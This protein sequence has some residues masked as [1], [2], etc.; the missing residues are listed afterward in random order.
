MIWQIHAGVSALKSLAPAPIRQYLKQRK[1]NRS[2]PSYDRGVVRQGTRLIEMIQAE[3][4]SLEGLTVLEIG[5]G[6]HPI[7]PVLFAA[8][9]VQKVILTDCERL[10]TEVS[11]LAA[12]NAVRS[13]SP[14]EI[15]DPF[16]ALG[17]EYIAPC[18]LTDLP[19]VDLVFSRAV[20]EQVPRL[21]LPA[22]LHSIHR[23]LKPGGIS[24]HIIDNTDYFSHFDPRLS[25]INFLTQSERFFH[26]T[27][28]N[29]FERTNRL[30]HS[31]YLEM[32]T[33]SGMELCQDGS[34][35]DQQALEDAY[36]LKL[37]PKFDGYLRTDLA[38]L[39]SWLIHKRGEGT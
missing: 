7:L 24:A 27:R 20:L 23:A 36:R 37:A 29:R 25:R 6:W 3:R 9:G 16:G 35:V 28:P 13:P 32:I 11:L 38:V 30:R 19:P 26:L 31:D 39:E 12:I 33:E 5:T 10:C 17:F 2:N 1:P 15:R 22:L 21:K 8:A 14:A 18:D 34:I 4:G